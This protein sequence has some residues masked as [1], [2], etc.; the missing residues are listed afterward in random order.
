MRPVLVWDCQILMYKQGSIGPNSRAPAT[1]SCI[2]CTCRLV[3]SCCNN[4]SDG[5]SH[6][7]LSLTDCRQVVGGMLAMLK[8]VKCY[9]SVKPAGPSL[10]ALKCSAPIAQYASADLCMKSF[11]FCVKS[12]MYLAGLPPQIWPAS[13]TVFGCTTAPAAT[14][15]PLC[16]WTQAQHPAVRRD[17]WHMLSQSPCMEVLL[18]KR[19]KQ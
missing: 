6:C 9:K 4:A 1:K 5:V 14:R 19:S 7:M 16:T 15:A 17:V 2:A 11:S 12:L 18:M 10:V 13:T 3:P 8:I